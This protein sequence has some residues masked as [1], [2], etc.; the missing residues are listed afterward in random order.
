MLAGPRPILESFG[1]KEVMID[2]IFDCAFFQTVVSEVHNSVADKD[3]L[4][5][6]FVIC[7]CLQIVPVN[8]RCKVRNVF[9]CIRFP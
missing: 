5:V 3:S 9:A 1:V 7:F 8:S 6:D 4:E 2:K